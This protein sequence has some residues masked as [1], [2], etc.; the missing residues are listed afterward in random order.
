MPTTIA[1]LCGGPS[2]ER[3]ISLNSARSVLDHLGAD[4]EIV[5][6]YLDLL[7]NPY[8][9]SIGQLYSNTPSDFD[10]KLARTASPLKPDQLVHA[11][12]EVDLVFPLIHGAYGEGGELQSFLEVNGIPFIGSSS[13]ACR[14]VFDK[15]QANE[16]LKQ[17][18]YFTYPQLLVK[19]SQPIREVEQNLEKFFAEHSLER[20][21]VK[22]A[23]GGSSICVFSVSSPQQTLDKISL[24]FARKIDHRVVVEPFVQGT[25]FTCIVLQDR[26][27]RPVALLPT[28][29]ETDY[30]G[31]EIFDYR[32]K[33]LPTSQVAHHCP[34][35]FEYTVVEA[36]RTQSEELFSL[37]G[38]RDF[39]RF[40]GWLDSLGR[41]WF[42]DFNPISGMEQNS[43]LFQ[44]SARVGL[45]H[46]ALLKSILVNA[47]RRE[48]VPLRPI[49]AGNP[50]Q[51]RKPV[52]VLFGGSTSER[53]VSLMSGTN[54]W[55]K[56]RRSSRYAPRPFLLDLEHQVW[57]LPY[58]LTLYHTV[59]EIMDNCAQAGQDAE[60]MRPLA[61]EI[62]HRL[63]SEPPGSGDD[64]FIP[65]KMS[66]EEFLD[67][68]PF[69]FI[70]L[71]GGLGEDGRLQAMLEKR[72]IPFNGPGEGPSRTAMDK[73]ETGEIVDRLNIGGVSS[74]PK[75]LVPLGT[76][77]PGD[78]QAVRRTFAETLET[79]K[80]ET[81]L[82]KPRADGCSSGIVHLHGPEDLLAYLDFLRSRASFI[83]KNTFGGQKEHVELPL[84]EVDEL[85]LEKFISTDRIT[86]TDHTLEY[87]R[88]NGWIEI[89]AGVL[90]QEGRLQVFNPSLT[91][92]EGEV[93][94]VEEK[95][96]GGTGINITPPPEEV[97]GHQAIARA[98][99]LLLQVAQGFNIT[100]YARLDAFLEV[101]TGRVMLI[102]VNT[103]PA[104]TP[105][106][107]LFQQALSCDPPIFP[108]ELIETLIANKG[109]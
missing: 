13:R 77:P 49:E 14:Q 38:M 82:V 21:V 1:L 41:I 64:F 74:V 99:D 24:I 67:S 93:L 58:G 87:E 11:L 91:V 104:L 30:E 76:L 69:V 26:K 94:T 106:T 34:P 25:E 86:V 15:H 80:C 29:I 51:T 3:G 37:F 73:W 7:K 101:D 78:S 89:T 23:A 108:R 12:Q 56:L 9:I 98:K 105:S 43:F 20:A 97:V 17:L 88:V 8:R 57:E 48:A 39:A 18:G 33:Y 2:L 47:C 70:G 10:F 72:S 75:S 107:V 16:R 35:R 5:P 92:S 27:H 100:G 85:L 81:L 95:F 50:H 62:K 54:A 83:P 71:H 109:Y 6:F 42:S 103:L 61:G 63:M 19:E 90:E 84:Q 31:H 46:R 45:S 55:L 79:L 32:K 22:P 28:E 52:H 4:V 40:D 96:Q 66:L 44:Q 59:E 53:Q 102:E 60:A 65:R 68:S 36:I